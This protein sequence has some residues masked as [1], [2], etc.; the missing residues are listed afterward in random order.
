VQKQ[1]EI[2]NKILKLAG[3]DNRVRAVLLNG[4]RANPKVKPDKYQD[5]DIVFVVQDF[6]T[7]LSDRSWISLLGKPILQ[8]LPDEMILGRDQNQEKGSFSFLMIFEDGHRIDLTLFPREKLGTDFE[9]DSL[10][11]VWLDKDELFKDVPAPT[12]KDYHIATPSQQT[13]SEVCNEFWWTITYVAKGLKRKEVIYAK[14]MLETVVRPMFLQMIAW[15][16]GYDF[17]F[18]ISMGKSGKSA[19]KYLDSSFYGEILKT[20]TDANI[21]NNWNS[22]FLMANIFKEEQ[23]KLT[24]KLFGHRNYSNVN[25]AKHALEYIQ[26]LRYE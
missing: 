3:N 13:F 9:A 14:D 16:I 21:E 19:D 18:K 25:E 22:L 1:E 23:I 24:K 15:K 12:D 7:F 5:F 20:Y 17:D 10:T 6:D 4:S 11:I 2:K 8:Q 26:K